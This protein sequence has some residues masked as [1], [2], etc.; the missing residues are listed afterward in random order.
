MPPTQPPCWYLCRVGG[1]SGLTN[2]VTNESLKPLLILAFKFN[3]TVFS[4]GG[5]HDGR[6]GNDGDGTEYLWPEADI[7]Y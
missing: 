2:D 4:S 6:T 3:W 1:E 7:S 5:R